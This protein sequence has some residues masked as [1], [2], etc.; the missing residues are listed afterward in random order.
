MPIIKFDYRTSTETVTYTWSSLQSLKTLQSMKSDIGK[1]NTTTTNDVINLAYPNTKQMID[2][3]IQFS[4]LPNRSKHTLYDSN[5][6][7]IPKEILNR[8]SDIVTISPDEEAFFESTLENW[9]KAKICQLIDCSV[10]MQF[11]ELELKTSK[12]I[13]NKFIKI[14]KSNENPIADLRKFY[15]LPTHLSD[16]ELQNLSILNIH[17]ETEYITL[18]SKLLKCIF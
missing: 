18:L 10:F 2:I 13:Q 6:F 11:Y 3:M 12:Y 14:A 15:G 9:S 8:L 17:E 16:I 4:K 5:P 7:D 1:F